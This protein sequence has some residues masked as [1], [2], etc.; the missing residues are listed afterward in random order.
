MAEEEKR[1]ALFSY[2]F[3]LITSFSSVV[4]LLVTQIR[5]PFNEKKYNHECFCN[6]GATTYTNTGCS[7]ILG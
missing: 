5:T 1:F 4:E 3:F 7:K 2:F 6:V